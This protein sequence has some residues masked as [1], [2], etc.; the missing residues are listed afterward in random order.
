MAQNCA[1]SSDLIIHRVLE[2]EDLG[3]DFKKSELVDLFEVGVIDP[4]KVTR[5]AVQNSISAAGTL[6]TTN[7]AIIEE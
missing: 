4:A 5:V 3:W 1:E 2:S 6:I 7:N